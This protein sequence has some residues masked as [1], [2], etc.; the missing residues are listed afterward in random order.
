MNRRS[1]LGRGLAALIPQAPTLDDDSRATEPPMSSDT[2][3]RDHDHGNDEEALVSDQHGGR[4]AGGEQ[5]RSAA[6]QSVSDRDA[7][8]TSP[9]GAS[10]PASTPLRHGATDAAEGHAAEGAARGGSATDSLVS[11]S[12][13]TLTELD[14][15]Q[16]VPNPRQPREVF[17]PEELEGLATSL[18][19]LG[20]LQPVVVRP[21]DDGGY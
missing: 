16:I 19:D 4:G 7:D 20:M 14:P 15:H 6:S 3:E 8:E 5:H 17:E 1:G 21:L 18:A 13:A 2:G 10:A 12:A 11:A 9:D